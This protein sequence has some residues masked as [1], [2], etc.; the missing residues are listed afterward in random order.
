MRLISFLFNHRRRLEFC[1]QLTQ[2]LLA[3]VTKT[4]AFPMELVLRRLASTGCHHRCP[5]G[6]NDSDKA[7][8]P[9]KLKISIVATDHEISHG[10]NF[11]G[12]L[13]AKGPALAVSATATRNSLW[14][15][16]Q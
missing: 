14:V 4:E 1:F 8:V 16:R 13:Q 7:H 9:G 15:R 10:L 5:P 3:L 6:D 2:R 12:T 11:A